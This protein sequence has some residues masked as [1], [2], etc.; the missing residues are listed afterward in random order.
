MRSWERTVGF[1]YRRWNKRATWG[2]KWLL[3]GGKLP[4]SLGSKPLQARNTIILAGF[5]TIG[6]VWWLVKPQHIV[7]IDIIPSYQQEVPHLFRAQN[8]ETTESSSLS[9]PITPFFW[10]FKARSL[11]PYPMSASALYDFLARYSAKPEVIEFGLGSLNRL[12]KRFH[13]PGPTLSLCTTFSVLHICLRNP[14]Y[15]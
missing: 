11:G 13:H 14:S 7:V 2:L 15:R 6:L 4:R 5:C 10:V 9:N 12:L 1:I 3:I 8:A